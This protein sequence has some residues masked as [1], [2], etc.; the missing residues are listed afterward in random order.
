MTRVAEL[1]VAVPTRN[2]PAMLATCL[3]A[4]EAAREHRTFDAVICDSSSGENAAATAD[5]VARY[6]WARYVPHTLDGPCAAR[7]LGAHAA[8]GELL[9][10]VDDDVYVE[11]EA[12]AL[13]AAQV[14]QATAPTVVAGTF[15]FDGVLFSEPQVMRPNGFSRP[16][17]PGEPREWL[18]SALLCC[19][20]A[21]V[22][23]CPWDEQR[24]YYD[25][26]FTSLLWRRHGVQLGFAPEARAYHDEQRKAY[27]L[28]QERHRIYANAFDAIFLRRSARWLLAFELL[29][30]LTAAKRFARTPRGAFG[31][32]AEWI[33]GNARFVRDLPHLRRAGLPGHPVGEPA[34]LTAALP[35]PSA[36]RG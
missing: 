25:D 16:A 22:L 32:V 11:P 10:Y 7:N 34:C 8:T 24:R 14:E 6:E 26:R 30:F 31:I 18:I 12:I 29:G 15:T 33:R 3:E 2:R 27:P 9:A 1:T 13:L 19:P 36:V 17:Q 20:R 35:A 4:L 21:I 28:A 5:V 23:A